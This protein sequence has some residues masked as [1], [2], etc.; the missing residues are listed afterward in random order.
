[1][2]LLIGPFV[3][4]ETAEDL[5]REIMV[6]SKVKEQVEVMIDQMFTMIKAQRSD[7]T[8]E[9]IEELQAEL[10]PNEIIELCIPAYTK[11]L[12]VEELEGLL[13]FYKTPLGQSFA[14]K[15]I[16]ITR[17]TTIIGQQ[18]GANISQKIAERIQK[19]LKK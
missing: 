3:K 4:A 17:E 5:A 13:A 9:L 6:I 12:T 11:H 14:E 10:D 7:L 2:M 15:Q 8:P 19:S 18:W 16:L 1:M